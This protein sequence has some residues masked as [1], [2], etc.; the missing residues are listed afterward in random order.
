MNDVKIKLRRIYDELCDE[1]DFHYKD[2]EITIS[3]RLRSSNGRI[4][5]RLDFFGTLTRAKIVMSKALLDEF[6][7][8]EFEKTFRHEVAHLA[9]ILIHKSRG[10]DR[11]FKILCQKFGG[12]MNTGMA[13]GEFRDCAS[14]DYVRPIIRWEYICSGCGYT[15]KMAKRMNRRK[16]GSENYSCGR[17]RTSLDK[18]EEKQLV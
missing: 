14:T 13:R 16:R 7:W 2:L 4:K 3:N 17:C 1:Y 15:K 18:W 9:N 11:T 10:H 12:S 8:G 5:W 6:G